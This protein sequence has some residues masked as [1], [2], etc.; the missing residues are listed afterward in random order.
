MMM[1]FN[2]LTLATAALLAVSTIASAQSYDDAYVTRDELPNG[3]IFLPAPPD[4][5]DAA[6]FN[7]WLVYNRGLEKR[8]TPRG[9]QAQADAEYSWSYMA[10]Y[11]SK[12]MGFEIS[13]EKTP[14]IYRLL[15]RAANTGGDATYK[16][17]RHYMRRRPFMVF[18]QHTMTPDHEPGLSRNG[19]YPSGHTSMGWATALVLAEVNPAAQDSILLLGYEYGQSRTI[20][21]AHWQSDVDAGRVT[22]SAAVA[23]MHCSPDFQADMAAAKAECDK[24]LGKSSVKGPNIMSKENAN[25]RRLRSK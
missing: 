11:Y 20:V 7:D 5:T 24:I 8:P 12:A 13:P 3:T 14:A 16:P 19:S 9:E 25:R 23:R 10:K 18:N 22:A 15:C 6:F 1:I 4:T 2:R 21:G 17:K